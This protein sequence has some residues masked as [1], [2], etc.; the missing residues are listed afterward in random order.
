MTAQQMAQFTDDAVLTIDEAREHIAATALVDSG[1]HRVGL[2]L[3]GHLV[4]LADP[5]TRPS[6]PTVATVVGD[7]PG[8]PGSSR[9]TVEPGGQV[10]LSTPPLPDVTAAVRALGRD[11]TALRAHLREHGL[12]VAAIG[13]DPCRGP[14]RINPGS[15]YL[16]MEQHFAATRQGRPARAMMTATAALQ[17]NLDAGPASGWRERVAHIHAVLPV[18]VAAAAS[19]PYL[20][21]RASGWQSMRRQVWQELDPGRTAPVPGGDPSAAWADYALAAPVMLVRDDQSARPVLSRVAFEAWVLGHAAFDRPPT[22]ADLDYH[23]STLFPPVRPRGYLELRGL[24]ALPERWWP[25]L[26]ALTVALIDDPV[27]ADRAREACAPLTEGRAAQSGVADPAVRHA[28]L[29]CL[30]VATSRTPQVLRPALDDLAELVDAGS[31][32]SDLL[33]HRIEQ[34]GPLRVLREEADA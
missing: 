11:W 34:S 20:A 29:H 13:A 19:S 32:V 8:L 6:W 21:G 16:A 28:V 5:G 27:A 25:A 4:D 23:L 3:E 30:E 15:R 18:L 14:L 22:R 12:G 2:E 9:V 31:S 33:R 17:V 1:R 26:V 7:V 24:D 10:E